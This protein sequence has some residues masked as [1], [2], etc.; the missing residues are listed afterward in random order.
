[1][2][3]HTTNYWKDTSRNSSQQLVKRNTPM[4]KFVHC[5]A[6]IMHVITDFC[7]EVEG[8]LQTTILL[9]LAKLA[10]NID[11]SVLHD[12]SI[13][14]SISSLNIYCF[15]IHFHSTI[16]YSFV[17]IH[18]PCKDNV[19]LVFTYIFRQCCKYD[20]FCVPDVS[21]TF[22]GYINEKIFPHLPKFKTSC[23]LPTQY[24]YNFGWLHGHTTNRQN[25][26]IT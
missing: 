11:T 4:F 21:I 5:F 6:F 2:A 9:Q 19:Y 15:Y 14:T 18:S 17:T 10:C 12:K 13:S 1:M 24:S 8:I 25:A 23:C 20:Y 16:A 3:K 7:G 26:N 22:V